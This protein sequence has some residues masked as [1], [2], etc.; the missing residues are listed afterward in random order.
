M[1]ETK[2]RT[3]FD[4]MGAIMGIL[5]HFCHKKKRGCVQNAASFLTYAR[6]CFG[7]ATSF[8]KGR[9]PS[10][11]ICFA[12]RMP[13][14]WEDYT[15]N[16]VVFFFRTNSQNY[17]RSVQSIYVMDNPSSMYTFSLTTFENG[18]FAVSPKAPLYDRSVPLIDS[19]L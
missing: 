16:E 6:C 9:F 17:I 5:L 10:R 4:A 13:C 8:Y 15:P 14:S 19:S 3:I 7:I 1:P 2:D 11:A 12:C 18:V